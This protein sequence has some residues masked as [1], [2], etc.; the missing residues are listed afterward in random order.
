MQVATRGSGPPLVFVPGIQGRWE[1]MAPAID[2][3]S[4]SLRILTFW[5][6]GERQDD[7]WF[8]PAKGLDNYVEQIE[9][10]MDEHGIERAAIC[11]VS[12]GGLAA[13]RFAASRPDRTA[14]LILVST[15]APWW[16][17]LRRHLFYGRV[18]WLF[19]LLFLLETHL[20]TR[21]ELASA[22]SSWGSRL[23]FVL[24]QLR[25]VARTGF[26]LRNM[27]RRA[28]LF[29]APGLTSDCLRITAPTLVVHGESPL[30]R[31][32]P[33]EATLEYL[34]RIRG[35]EGVVLEH[36][37]HLGLVTRPDA[38]ASAV[39]GFLQRIGSFSSERG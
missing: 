22:F 35:A 34:T 29:A 33:V 9:Q 5:L 30:D 24:S 27:A 11:G 25:T 39:T 12:F 37:G 23:R 4:A 1:Y 31:V 6:R 16:R 36:T 28:R 18:P 17:P 32:V 21:A 13:L 20:R 38:F 15:P 8:D 7:G 14:A 10:A 2:A 3:L 26:S 19:G